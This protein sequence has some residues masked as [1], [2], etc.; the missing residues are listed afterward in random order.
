M[1]YIDERSGPMVERKYILFLLQA[2]INVLQCFMLYCVE[3]QYVSVISFI[4]DVF[5]VRD[6][7]L[8]AT[9]HP[10][11]SCVQDSCVLV[12]TLLGHPITQQLLYQE[13]PPR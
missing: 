8:S 9:T 5:I 10:L 3:T 1:G 4:N 7:V 13:C 2:R 11:R 12:T 6:R